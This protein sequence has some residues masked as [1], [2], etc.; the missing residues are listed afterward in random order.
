MPATSKGT[1][2][3][4]LL[5]ISDIVNIQDSNGLFGELLSSLQ[6]WFN[7][8]CSCDGY[9]SLS[10]PNMTCIDKQTG[11]VT[12][13]IH[14]NGLSSAQEL[15]DLVTVDIA[16]RD[17]PVIYLSHGW[18]LCLNTS[19]KPSKIETKFNGN[20]DMLITVSFAS[21]ST[22]LALLLCIIITAG[23]VYI[24]HKR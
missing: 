9:K 20:D 2:I 15:I 17:P 11:I 21:L 3:V 5:K 6:L 24:K 23:I 8:A 18:I 19:S 13:T 4:L 10:H 16:S 1:Y 7:S 22:I 14:P 12:T